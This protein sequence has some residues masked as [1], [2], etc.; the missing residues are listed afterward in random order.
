MNYQNASQ[1]L[2]EEVIN[3][4]QEYIQGEFLYIP[5]REES[6]KRWGDDSGIKKELRRRNMEIYEKHINGIKVHEL[7]RIYFLSEKS[8][9]RI[10]LSEKRMTE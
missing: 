5:K 3:I 9:Q 10:L 6:K 2:P 8:I 4:I 1:V 7:A